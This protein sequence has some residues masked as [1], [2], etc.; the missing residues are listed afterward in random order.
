MK[1]ASTL[2]FMLPGVPSI[3]YGDEIS[4][5]GYKDPFNRAY[6]AWD[7]TKCELHA[8]YVRLGKLRKENAVS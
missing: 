4:M 8:H 6:F 3:Y 1:M 7:N 2:Q 5:Q